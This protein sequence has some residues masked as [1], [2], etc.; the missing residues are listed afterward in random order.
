MSQI[1]IILGSIS[2]KVIFEKSK[3]IFNVF[4]IKY[5]LRIASAH[6]TPEKIEE[7]VKNSNSEVFIAIAGLSAALPGAIA[8]NTIKPV[9]GVPVESKL[10]GLDALLSIVQMPPG[11][12]VACVGIDRG[13]NA[14]LLAIEI[15]ALK[16]DDLK[17]KLK[18]YREKMK[19]K[20]NND[21]KE[22]QQW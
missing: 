21:N 15:L 2:D 10:D 5:D 6:R 22:A 19:E 11:I 9:I 3:A 12:P 18:N 14:A 16:D 17:N 20:I 13:E 4:E 7:I 8:A 1:T